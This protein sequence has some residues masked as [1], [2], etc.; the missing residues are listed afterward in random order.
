MIDLVQPYVVVTSAAAASGAALCSSRRLR[1]ARA[2][3]A[4]AG[5]PSALAFVLAHR[6]EYDVFLEVRH[7]RRAAARARCAVRARTR[8]HAAAGDRR[9]GRSSA[10]LVAR[11]VGRGRGRAGGRHAAG[12]GAVGRPRA[13]APGHRGDSRESRLVRV[14]CVAV[15]AAAA[16]C[17]DQHRWRR[18]ALGGWWPHESVGRVLPA[19]C[20]VRHVPRRHQ[21]WRGLRALRSVS[22]PSL[23]F[24]LAPPRPCGCLE[25]ACAP[26]SLSRLSCCSC[27]QAAVY[28]M[29]PRASVDST[30][31]VA[32]N[33]ALPSGMSPQTH[34][35][36]ARS[37]DGYAANVAGHIVR[38]QRYWSTKVRARAPA[39]VRRDTR[40]MHARARAADICRGRAVG[41]CAAER[42]RLEREQRLRHGVCRQRRRLEQRCGKRQR[43]L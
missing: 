10:R 13:A 37:I 33:A 34:L 7:T 9:H 16:R 31:G 26:V 30:W 24:F 40:S 36:R 41:C 42:Q 18:H 1:G 4:P 12:A 43:R 8:A 15:N 6:A 25:C 22:C 14:R 27:V 35:A 2:L 23:A 20:R 39:R 29:A 11:C 38:G 17:D 5:D 28:I 19:L 21:P 3:Q 32:G